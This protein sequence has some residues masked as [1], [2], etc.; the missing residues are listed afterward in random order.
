MVAW[1]ADRWDALPPNHQARAGMMRKWSMGNK[2]PKPGGRAPVIFFDPPSRT[3]EPIV[4][5]AADGRGRQLAM[6]AT[7]D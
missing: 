5:F 3:P 2:L 6:A 1:I 7:Q 4:S